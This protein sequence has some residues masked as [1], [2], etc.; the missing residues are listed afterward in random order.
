MTRHQNSFLPYGRQ[1]I[2]DE[3]VAA[4]QAI[5]HNDFLTTGP[6]VDEFE[7]KFAETVGSQYA[8]AC[9]NGTAA[10]HLAA[11]ALGIGPG[12]RVIVP[13]VTFLAT[14][15]AIRYVGADVVFADIDPDTGQMEPEQLA[16]AANTQEGRDARAVF[17]VCLTGTTADPKEIADA[18]GGREIACDASHALGTKYTS[19][20]ERGTIGDCR[21]AAMTTFSFHPVKT[22]TL[23]E[24]GAVST[25]DDTLDRRLR[26]FRN[27][28]MTREADSFTNAEMGFDAGGDPNPW[29]Y[30]MAEPGYN[31]RLT[32]LQCALG[33]SQLR[34][35]DRFAAQRR[36]LAARYAEL[37]GPLSPHVRLLTTSDRCEPVRHLAVVLIDF[38]ALGTN[39]ARVMHQLRAGG[40]GTQVHYIPVHKQPYYR[41]LYGELDLPGAEAYYERTLS[42]PLFAGME[43]SDVDRVVEI[44][45]TTLGLDKNL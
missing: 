27:H 20:N 45:S 37:I 44:L 36:L 10:L 28:G 30:E 13:S 21:H 42:L 29:Y 18:A 33:L 26:L 39:R 35:L 41:N 43:T 16:A 4:V 34:K 2:D 32:D 24:G 6:L 12:D 3:D 31:Y 25:S 38:A 5:L 1:E 19:G 7:S 9:S 15:N 22:I 14:A 11:L 40:I 8:I 17:T 23:A